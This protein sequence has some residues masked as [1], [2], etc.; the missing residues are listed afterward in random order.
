MAFGKYT[1]WRG[2]TYRGGG[3]MPDRVVDGQE[4]RRRQGDA[5]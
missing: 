4:P 2:L 1:G 5:A 3:P